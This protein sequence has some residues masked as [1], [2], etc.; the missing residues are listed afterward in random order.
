MKGKKEQIPTWLWIMA[1]LFI[2]M[3]FYM[4]EQNKKEV[5]QMYR[6]FKIDYCRGMSD[7]ECWDLFNEGA[8]P[9]PESTR[10]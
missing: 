5:Q 1:I 9:A 8:A 6:D 3:I 7:K 10:W 4:R 2:C